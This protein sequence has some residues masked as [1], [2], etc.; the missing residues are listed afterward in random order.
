VFSFS[1]EKMDEVTISCLGLLLQEFFNPA[2]VI[3]SIDFCLMNEDYDLLLINLIRE[4]HFRFTIWS[5]DWINKFTARDFHD[6]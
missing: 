4:T 5:E 1:F 2:E 3:D 6:M